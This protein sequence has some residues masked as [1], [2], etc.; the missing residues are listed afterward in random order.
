MRNV[1]V[2]AWGAL[3]MAKQGNKGKAHHSGAHA[4]ARQAIT[5]R[6][7]ARRQKKRAK[8][9][10]KRRAKHGGCAVKESNRHSW[11]IK[12]G[13]GHDYMAPKPKA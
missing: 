11:M 2:N 3:A 1:N 10:I 5:L 7:K 12:N 9:L 4:V 13:F 8:W 6:N